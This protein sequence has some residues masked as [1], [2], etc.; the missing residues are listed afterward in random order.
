MAMS[1]SAEAEAEEYKSEQGT[2]FGFEFEDFSPASPEL[3]I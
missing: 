3:N 2:E 1:L